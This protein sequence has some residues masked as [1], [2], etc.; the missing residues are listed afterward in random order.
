MVE[1]ESFFL[2]LSNLTIRKNCITQSQS[3]I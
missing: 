3:A 1:I 2:Q